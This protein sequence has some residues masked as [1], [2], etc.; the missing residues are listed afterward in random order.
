MEIVR[1]VVLFALV[2]G[3]AASDPPPAAVPTATAPLASG[4]SEPALAPSAR[5]P[6]VVTLAFSMDAGAPDDA[7]VAAST[8]APDDDLGPDSCGNAPKLDYRAR[9]GASASSAITAE[10]SPF[11]FFAVKTPVP[12]G[13]AN[14]P[15]QIRLD[16][17]SRIA[18]SKPM[19]LKASVTNVAKKALT[20][21]LAVDGS[22]EHWRSPFVDLYARDEA[23][24]RVYRY[25]FHGGRCGN[26]NTRTKADFAT[27]AAGA[28]REPAFGE[29][30]N[31]VQTASID[32]PGRYSLWV[33]YTS[34]KGPDYGL[35]LGVGGAPRLPVPYRGV[36]ASAPVVVEVTP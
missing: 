33:V 25:D 10:P 1:S 7:A 29:W 23:S 31:H 26:V 32:V 11:G 2:A 36:V 18:A 15:L 6:E 8:P 20:L 16:A 13:D 22:L 24:G 17:P 27:V 3:C 4:P 35:A 5:A 21:A 34:C 14:A 12:A 9:L 30:S 19:G 28:V